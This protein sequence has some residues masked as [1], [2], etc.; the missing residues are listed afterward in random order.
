MPCFRPTTATISTPSSGR[1]SPSFLRS[2]WDSRAVSRDRRCASPLTK[3]SG[4]RSALM[5]YRRRGVFVPSFGGRAGPTR[6][7]SSTRSHRKSRATSSNG[8][9]A[10]ATPIDWSSLIA[11][12]VS[13]REEASFVPD[14]GAV[15][16]AVFQQSPSRLLIDCSV[17]RGVEM[18]RSLPVILF[19][20]GTVVY[21]ANIGC[22]R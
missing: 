1:R 3:Y 12:A 19:W 15:T 2:T 18:N 11:S 6:Q 21:G 7:A 10:C 9:S 22:F 20:H 4:A 17:T 16:H 5:G 8:A 14:S 13:R